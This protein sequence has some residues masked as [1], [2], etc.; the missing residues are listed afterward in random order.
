MSKK[1]I[2]IIAAMLFT[3]N[4]IAQ[5]LNIHVVGTWDEKSNG[6]VIRTWIFHRDGTKTLK[7]RT[8]MIYPIG[9]IETTFDL[10]QE[11]KDEKWSTTVSGGLLLMKF[12][13]IPLNDLKISVDYK[14]YA[15]YTV[16]QQ[17][18][19]KAALPAFI[20][21]VREETS[22]G[23]NMLAGRQSTYEIVYNSPQKMILNDGQSDY[24]LI[25]NTAVMSPAERATFDKEVKAFEET[26]SRSSNHGKTSSNSI[27]SD[28]KVYDTVEQ[29]PSFPGGMPAMMS[30]VKTHVQYPPEAREKG[31][32][33][34]VVVKFIV[35]KDGSLV[36]VE[37]GNSVDP[38][39][40][41]EAVRVV[42]SMP[43]WIPGKNRGVTVRVKSHAI[44]KIVDN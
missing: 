35:E 6:Q 20:R 2:M 22:K 19:I 38:I 3:I 31:I 4:A 28:D 29:M 42:Q 16:A 26:V 1:M 14:K 39:L 8:K 9:G 18:K 5:T 33:G 10:I 11:R 27:G 23:W 36:N 30:W 7:G 24:V 37:A 43:K 44:V 21:Q 12:T 40:A 25:R 41:K 15:K 34:N 13:V 17:Q 32:Q